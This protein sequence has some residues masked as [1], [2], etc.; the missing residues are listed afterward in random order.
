MLIP[1]KQ[2]WMNRWRTLRSVYRGVIQSGKV[3]DSAIL[4]AMEF[5]RPY[6]RVAPIEKERN[7]SEEIA[8][9][10]V[11]VTTATPKTSHQLNRE[12]TV[13]TFCIQ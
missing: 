1:D 5:L 10:Q 13:N 4:H 9:E 11:L 2:H 7:A 12:A 8:T 6:M 3:K